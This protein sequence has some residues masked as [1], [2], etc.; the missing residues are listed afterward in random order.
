MVGPFPIV[1][2]G[3]LALKQISK[4]LANA[5]K[6]RAKSSPFF[7]NYVCMPPAQ[8]YH[9]MDVN[10]RLKLMGMG[11]ATHVDKLSD[12]MA[13]ELGAE[14]LGEFILFTSAS[15]IL[16][17][18]YSRS[19]AK[20][21]LKEQAMLQKDLELERRLQELGLISEMQDAKIRELERTVGDLDSRNLSLASKLF[22][23]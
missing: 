21:E 9:W 18:E 13:I 10:V 8:I 14:M 3:Y 23:K 17:M 4:P 11:K 15:I 20:E 5:L 2:L 7:R 12:S 6:S 16:Y 19:A 22:G 1:K